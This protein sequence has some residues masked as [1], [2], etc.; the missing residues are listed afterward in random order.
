MK[1]AIYHKG[2]VERA[3]VSFPRLSHRAHMTKEMLAAAIA[4]AKCDRFQPKT[5][6]VFFNAI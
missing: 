5:W 2:P 6:N 1:A 4:E 3:G